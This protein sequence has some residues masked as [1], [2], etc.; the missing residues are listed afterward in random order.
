MTKITLRCATLAD[1]PL[2][3]YWDT[4]PHVIFATGADEPFDW[5]PEVARN[6]PWLEI[7]IAEADG[8]P[9]GVVQIIDPLNE[10]SHYWGDVEPNLRAIDIWIGEESDLGRGYGTEMMRLALKQCFT[11]PEAEAI[12]IDPLQVN[13]GAIRFYERLGFRRIGARRFNS[14]DCFVY[15]LDR[16]DWECKQC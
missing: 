15:R 11:R 6:E 12:L 7:L 2:L 10:V 14:D 4:K 8:R 13:I 9:I 3:E 1:C 5:K 16:R